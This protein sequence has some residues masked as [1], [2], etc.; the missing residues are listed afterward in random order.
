[1]NSQIDLKQ[2]IIVRNRKKT[3]AEQA[4]PI[5]TPDLWAVI[6]ELKAERKTVSNAAG[7]VHTINGQPIPENLF[8]YWFRRAC[9]DAKLVNFR[10]HDLR[11][12]A[13]TAWAPAGIPT[14]AAMAAAGHLSVASHKKYQSLPREELKNAFRKL[15]QN[16]SKEKQQ[17]SDSA[18]SA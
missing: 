9:K 8:E 13:I 4:I 7:L 1:L 17:R 14:A 16:C 15:S 6:D 3:D 12:M 10:F 18:A 5:M 2:E 11:H